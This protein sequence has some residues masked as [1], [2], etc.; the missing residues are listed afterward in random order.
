MTTHYSESEERFV[1]ALARNIQGTSTTRHTGRDQAA[2]TC[3]AGKR[4]DIS[5][6]TQKTN[7]TALIRRVVTK[8]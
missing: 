8:R 2:H 5:D 3:I 1:Q 4:G 7:M 6:K